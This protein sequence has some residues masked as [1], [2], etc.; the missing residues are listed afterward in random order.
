MMMAISTAGLDLGGQ[1]ACHS[2]QPVQVGTVQSLGLQHLSQLALLI[3][4]VYPSRGSTQALDRLAVVL[5][6]QV[7][8]VLVCWELWLQ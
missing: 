3:R 8:L 4:S 2:D 6:V 5:P 7:L 1:A